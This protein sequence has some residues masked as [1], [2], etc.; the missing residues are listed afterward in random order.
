MICRFDRLCRATILAALLFSTVARADG[1]AYETKITGVEDSALQTD[2]KAN[3]QLVKL[4]DDKPPAT[5]GALTRRA[6][7]DTDRLT[8]VIEA[9]GYYE[10]HIE[11]VI[12]EKATP[13]TVEVKVTTGPRYTLTKVALTNQAG[14]TPP[15]IG[16][17]D[18]AAVGLI[19]GGPA[20]SEPVVGADAR[21]A[22]LYQ[23]KGYPFA[24]VVDK[25]VIVD[26]ATK[27]MEVTFVLDP[28]ARARFGALQVDG[29]ARLHEAWVLRR[30]KWTA[31]TAYDQAQVDETRQAMVSSGLFGTVNV[32]PVG[33]VTADGTVPMQVKIIERAP[34]SVGVGG[35]YDTTEG[36]S[37]NV[38]WEHRDLFGGGEDLKFTATG[39]TS[40]NSLSATFRRPDLWSDNQDFIASLIFDDQSVKAYDSIEQK[41]QVGLERHFD[42][43]FS[44]GASILAEHARV[45]EKVDYRTY[46]LVGLPVFLKKDG[47]DDLLNPTKGYRVALES[48]PYLRAIGSN[49]TFLQSKL[50]GSWYDQLTPSGNYILA[51]QGTLGSTLGTSLDA[52]PKDHRFYAGGGGSVR[53]F[54][55]QE[56]GPLDKFDNPIGG[57][58]LAVISAEFRTKITET[59]G[60]VPFLDAG[61]NY[62]SEVPDFKGRIA[63]GAG[64]GLRYYTAIGPVRLDLATPL[65]PRSGVD[66]P[67]Q[68]YVSLGQ[69]F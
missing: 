63:L 54:G 35:S 41:A 33:P 5:V 39:G 68:I 22:R 20:V 23:I 17:F 58:S 6:R 48:T 67:I 50:T 53:G 29:L 9:A 59:I 28:G 3:S 43:T 69:A 42:P 27:G 25:H 60:L 38:S 65:N 51:L 8:A 15:D 45:D 57:R 36:I 34:R 66:S 56:A 47:T 31:G 32:A 14:T 52:I 10:P 46:V 12:D 18:P 40:D 19:V 64:I 44:G 21:I 1:I 2:L 37:A 49:L 24:K 55:F 16:V 26:A 7:D 11:S 61:S 4:Q 30:I 13:I 62:A